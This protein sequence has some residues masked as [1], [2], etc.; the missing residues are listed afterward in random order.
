MSMNLPEQVA[1]VRR[2]N[3]FYTRQIGVLGPTYLGGPYA[4]SE[5]RMLYEIAHAEGVTPKALAELAGL[6][7]GYLSR[8]LGRF[9]RDGLVRRERSASDGRSVSLYLTE[10]GRR[11]FGDLQLRSDSQAEGLI[12]PLPARDRERLTGAMA[13]VERLMAAPAP[14]DILLRPHRVGD[15]GWVTW[16]H[17]VLYAREQGWDERF[18]AL[19]ARIVADFVEN[20]DPAR[21][22]CWIAERDGEIVGSVFLVTGDGDEAKLRLL[23]IEPSVRGRGLGR[24]LVAEC[25]S[26]AREAGY[27]GVTLWTQSILTAARGVYAGAGFQLTESQPHREF[28]CDL[29]GETW[30]LR[31]Q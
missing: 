2:F 9:E 27:G 13:D 14:A 5:G 11:V 17:A 19:V 10:D 3:R 21:E 18:E 4:L 22:R 24:R 8:I 1:A 12:G 25:V 26:F 15:M 6:D 28:G 20:F 23:L 31:F 16:R 7:P 29:I 30:K